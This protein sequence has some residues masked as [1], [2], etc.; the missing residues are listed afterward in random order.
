MGEEWRRGWHPENL[1]P[2]HAD[3]TVLVVG[4]GPAGLE[5]ARALGQRGYPVILA[6]ADEQPGGRINRE[7]RLP[8]MASYARVR[9][10][11]LGQLRALPNVQLYP[12]NRL[13]AASILDLDCRHVVLATGATWRSDGVGANGT[14]P[15]DGHD[16]E[17]VIGVEQVL[18]GVEARGRVLVYDD[19]HYYLASALALR[20]AGEGAEVVL[21]T[22]ADAVADWCRYTNEQSLLVESLLAA[23]VTLV[24]A[25]RITAFADGAA[26][27]ACVYGGAERTLA[28]DWL[29]PVGARRPNDELWHELRDREAEFRERGGLTLSRVGDCR[30]PGLI[31]GAVYDGH[32]VARELGGPVEAARRERVVL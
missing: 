27:A 30:A 28:A 29:L 17:R 5:A 31:A 16:G 3:E 13:D 10:W 26:R 4:A 18:R 6:E 20:L 8:G 22:P 2:R 9:D 23:G 15:I 24:T 32:R 7:A 25:R 12:D 21:V 19:E 14:R 11:R 1:P